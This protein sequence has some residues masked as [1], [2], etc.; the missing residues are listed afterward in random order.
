MSI[1]FSTVCID[2]V[3]LL[4]TVPA[5]SVGHVGRRVGEQEDMRTAAS[6][7]RDRVAASTLVTYR[8][9]AEDMT[10]LLLLLAAANT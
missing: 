4:C 9:F 6:H 1:G 8:V 5:L 3:T 7:S 10:L 2:V